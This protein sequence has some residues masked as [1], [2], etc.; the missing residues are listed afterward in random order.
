M[1]S[2]KIIGIVISVWLLTPAHAQSDAEAYDTAVVTDTLYSVHDTVRVDVRHF[3]DAKLKK[4][5]ADPDLK[6]ERS[7][8]VLSLWDRFKIWLAQ[9]I[10]RIFTF[11][12]ST[13]WGN[14]LIGVVCLAALIYVVLRLLRVDALQMFYRRHERGAMKMTVIEEDIHQMDF[15]KLLDNALRTNDYRLAIRLI[16]LQSLKILS[17]RHLI[18]WQPGKTNHDYLRELEA[19]PLR[20]GFED[21]NFY[22]EYAWYGNFTIREDLYRK[23]HSL[24][25]T[26]RNSA[27]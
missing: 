9:L 7:P 14:V 17:D 10:E 12:T 16:F 11:A 25:T 18:A 13:D 15:D 20:K 24:F 22:F 26:W 1:N 8:A 3:D 6:Y 19:T 2:I 21:L 27:S 23:V 5:Q 4:L